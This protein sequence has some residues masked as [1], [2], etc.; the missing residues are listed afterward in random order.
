M[1]QQ[2]RLLHH[3]I[4][5]GF[6][7]VFMTGC[8]V[9]VKPAPSPIPPTETN[10][11]P[12]SA[13][14]LATET[15]PSPT[16]ASHSELLWMTDGQSNT[17]SRSTELALDSQGNV[18]I[19]DG[20]YH[21]VQKFDKDGN[22]LLMWG[23]PGAGDGQFIFRNP[24]AH[25]GNITAD[26][27]GYVYVTDHNNRVQKFDSNGT[28]LMKFG[29]TGYGD[30]E[31]A[32]LYGVAVDDQGN[33]YTTDL[34]RYD[35]QKFDGGGNFLLKWEVPSCRP[36][37]TSMPHNLVVN[38]QGQLY[39]TNASGNCIQKFDGQ[40]NLL[41][42]WGELGAADGQ[43]HKP[44]GISLDTQGNVYVADNRNGRIQKFDANG[45]FLAQWGPFSFPDGVAVDDEG[46]VYV[47]EVVPAQLSKFRP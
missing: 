28:F 44:I 17:F 41:K 29:R 31:F 5:I 9:P 8:S 21:R 4:D 45:N 37:G 1:K 36:G 27:A 40:G 26:K 23:S 18:Y 2:Q 12:T 10:I 39:V 24:P 6:V 43:F 16:I 34:D 14:I 22:F 38:G 13:P 46:N 20:G 7:L 33:I 42:Q 25:Y 32:A 47:V 3:M 35:I 19:I 15:L 11:P 30:G